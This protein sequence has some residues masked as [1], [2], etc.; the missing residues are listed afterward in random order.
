MKIRETVRKA[1]SLS[2]ALL[3]AAGTA[4]ADGAAME[5]RGLDLSGSSLRYPVVTGLGDENLEK[6]V[7]EQIQ[8]DLNVSG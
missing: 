6:Q 5:E 7:N 3:L 4:A 1:L 8:A 2:A